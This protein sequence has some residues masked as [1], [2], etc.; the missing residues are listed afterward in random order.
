MEEI[1]RKDIHGK[2]HR[3]KYLKE[4]TETNGKKKLPK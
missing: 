3:R 4:S 2:I 1:T